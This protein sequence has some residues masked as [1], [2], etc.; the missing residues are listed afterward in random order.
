M[1]TQEARSRGVS[2]A[3]GE[4]LATQ[5]QQQVQD[6]AQDLKGQASE[7]IRK[8]LDTRSTDAGAQLDSFASALRRAAQELESDGKRAPAN[9]ARHAA[10]QVDRLG[11]YLRE[12]TADAFLN[13][14]EQFARRRPWAAGGL[15]A[16]LGLASSR[17]LKASSG[18]RYSA[19]QSSR[20][21]LDAPLT[22]SSAAGGTRPVSAPPALPPAHGGS[23]NES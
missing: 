19:A 17:F 7:T 10:G 23:R 9:V 6:K 22:R 16:A 13:D 18:R 11:R 12:G 5:V 15:G 21:D 2:D 3:E 1:A 14:V 4:G 8:Q 20:G